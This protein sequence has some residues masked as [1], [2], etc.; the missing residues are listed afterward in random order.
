[1]GMFHDEYVGHNNH[2]ISANPDDASYADIAAR[3]A[4]TAFHV[5]TNIDKVVRVGTT[6]VS[7]YI[8]S[9]I[10]PSVVWVDLSFKGA[11]GAGDVVGPATATDNAVALFDGTSGEI[12][13][14]STLLKIA[15]GLQIDGRIASKRGATVVEIFS[16]SDFPAPVSGVITLPN[17]KYTIRNTLTTGDRFY[18]APD[19][20]ISWQGEDSRTNIFTY[21]GTGTL[22]TCDNAERVDINDI[23]LLCTGAG[24]K[25]FDVTGG[26]FGISTGKLDITGANGTI[27]SVKDARTILIRNLT[28]LNYTFGITLDNIVTL[29]VNEVLIQNALAASSVMFSILTAIGFNCSFSVVV[30]VTRAGESIFYIDP[31]VRNGVE[32]DHVT[33]AGVG[34]FFES[35]VT[36]PIASF[37]DQSTAATAST[38]TD[39]GGQARFNLT[40]H[41]FSV[42]EIVDHTT[43][44]ETPY[45]GSHVITAVAT[46]TYEVGLAYIV[47][48]SGLTATTTVQV[49]DVA[50]GRSEGDSLSVFDTINF[51]G[52]YGIFN[53]QTDS[54]EI[55]LGRAFVAT[56]T[57]T[58]DT[59]SLNEASP[60]VDARDNGNEK[61]SKNLI[62]VHMNANAVVTT[63]ASADTYQA[64]DLTGLIADDT[65]EL[66]TLI[67]AADGVMRYDGL[68]DFIGTM[69]ATI[70]AIKTTALANYRFALSIDGAIP[71][72]ASAF[73]APMEVKTSKVGIPMIKPIRISPGQTVQLMIAGDGTTDNLTITDIALNLT[74]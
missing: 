60:Y 33:N 64:V 56:E 18:M 69:F 62:F 7:Y 16:M 9:E 25:V 39:N 19:A 73:Y 47:D 28:I 46:N 4:D 50:H 14:D 54:F 26:N 11:A 32:I 10:T 51:N 23:N 55:S 49:N 44:T 21:T 31:A 36:G 1:M 8:L 53:V 29:I 6:N 45:N 22:F 15:D 17:G 13:K 67:D 61:E 41:G 74:T 3:D 30:G 34:T 59:S 2:A 72:F 37:T 71:V 27:G 65:T 63:V 20:T 12:I 38:V 68:G 66:W 57:G 42:G 48:D 40:A 52:G 24:A 35:G 58:W 43:F 5:A 70:W